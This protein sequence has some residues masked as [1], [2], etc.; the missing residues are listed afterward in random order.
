[1]WRKSLTLATLRQQVEETSL[2]GSRSPRG[3]GP[4][5]PAELAQ[6]GCDRLE[7]FISFS[8]FLRFAIEQLIRCHLQFEDILKFSSVNDLLELI[9]LGR[10]GTRTL[11][12]TFLPEFSNTLNRILKIQNLHSELP[13]LK[14]NKQFSSLCLLFWR[15]FSMLLQYF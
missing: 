15:Y 10:K 13:P 4:I 12:N 1:M 14:I 8:N 2:S 11:S 3:K 7:A 9:L 5:P 6:R